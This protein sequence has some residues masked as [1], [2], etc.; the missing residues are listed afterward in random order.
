MWYTQFPLLLIIA[1]SLLGIILPD[2]P[3]PSD[4]PLLLD[5]PS[6]TAEDAGD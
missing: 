4:S 2:Y 5:T 3:T 1:W 6:L